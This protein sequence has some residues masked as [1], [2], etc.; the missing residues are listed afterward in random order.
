MQ[1]AQPTSCPPRPADP[2]VQLPTPPW[3]RLPSASTYLESSQGSQTPVCCVPPTA[4]DVGQI[5]G[6]VFLD[7][8]LT[9]VEMSPRHPSLLL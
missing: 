6:G 8:L 3:L 9:K 2:K 7:A 1:R 4:G 5:W